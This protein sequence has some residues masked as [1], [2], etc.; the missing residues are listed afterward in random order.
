MKNSPEP[1]TT[2]SSVDH[3]SSLASVLDGEIMQL[4]RRRDVVVAQRDSLDRE[5]KAIDDAI[6]VADNAITDLKDRQVGL[7]E[8]EQV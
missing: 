3:R 5:I 7:S 2:M 6:Q 1:V 4:S 8:R